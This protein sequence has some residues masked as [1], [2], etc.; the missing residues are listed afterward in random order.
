LGVEFNI[1]SSDL[2]LKFP[3]DH[4][5]PI[6][7]TPF[8]LNSLGLRPT[9]ARIDLNY[10]YEPWNIQIISKRANCM[11]SDS[12]AEEM[13]SFAKWINKNYGENNE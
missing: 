11:K 8:K 4:R 2:Y 7:N 12:S 3:K 1:S 13:L 9:I 6:L 5:C 10:G